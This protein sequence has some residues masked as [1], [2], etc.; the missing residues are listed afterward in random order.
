MRPSEEKASGARL[1]GRDDPEELP[2]FVH[3]LA[4][5]D[6]DALVK[7]GLLQIQRIHLIPGI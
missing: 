3:A 6:S 1:P 2:G 5:Q 7:A 4:F